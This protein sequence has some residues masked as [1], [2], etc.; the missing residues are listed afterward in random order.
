MVNPWTTESEWAW[1]AGVFEGEG[2]FGIVAP[3]V[4][5]T[6]VGRLGHS[7]GRTKVRLRIQM[8]DE[9]IVRRVHELTGVG[10]LTS[11]VRDD[12]PHWKEQWC[13]SCHKE[14]DVRAMI[15]ILEPWLG[16]RRRAKAR[17]CLDALDSRP[18]KAKSGP[19]RKT[20]AIEGQLGW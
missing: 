20:S 9:D 2:N 8:T 14:G 5:K 10:T 12:K 4:N 16:E 19:K 15:A 6:T 3:Y 13:W 17:E 18:P 7:V 11:V 1:V